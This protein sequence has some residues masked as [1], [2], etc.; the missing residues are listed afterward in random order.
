MLCIRFVD[1]SGNHGKWVL[2][3]WK[4]GQHFWA[5]TEAALPSQLTVKLRPGWNQ[6]MIKVVNGVR[7]WA[8]SVRAVEPDSDQPAK[9][10]EFSATPPE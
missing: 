4:N 8:L 10:L 9:D 6:L 5:R 7:D 1:Q 2:H 3:D